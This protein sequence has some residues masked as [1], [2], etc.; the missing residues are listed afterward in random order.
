M[1]NNAI[2]AEKINYLINYI[3]KQFSQS[4]GLRLNSND[5]KVF[6]HVR[7]PELYK[8]VINGTIKFQTDSYISG[9][10]YTQYLKL[11]DY[12]KLEAPLLLLFL[13]GTTEQEIINYMVEFF[14]RTEVKMFCNDPSFCLTGDTQIPLIDGSVKSMKILYD[15]YNIGK[16][17]WVYSS[18]GQK[19]T[20]GKIKKVWI[21]GN[22]NI[23]TKIVLS[24]GNELTTTPEHFYITSE[25]IPIMANQLEIGQKLLSE[26]DI[27]V[28]D[29]QTVILDKSVN[30]YDMEIE[31]EYHNFRVT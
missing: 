19:E 24:N 9:K 8:F 29:I 26:K 14:S 30:V 17:N 25:N 18:S 31:N 5:W 4:K 15:D 10:T 27:F 7:T 12:K 16:E 3:E 23:L 2:I 1:S 28:K 21:S 6:I 11:S 13:V 22:V 20:W